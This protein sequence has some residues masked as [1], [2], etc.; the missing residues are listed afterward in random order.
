MYALVV[1][2]L[3]GFLN[4]TCSLAVPLLKVSKLTTDSAARAVPRLNTGAVF[5]PTTIM[6][7][8]CSSHSDGVPLSVTRTVTTVVLGP[9]GGVQVNVPV[10]GLIEAP[11]GTVPTRL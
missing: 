9:A 3:R 8:V 5:A 10:L 4:I 1:V 11:E 6:V 7:T 2:E